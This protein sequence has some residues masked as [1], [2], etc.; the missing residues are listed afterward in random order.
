[1]KF[2]VIGYGFVGKAVVTTLEKNYKVNIIDPALGFEDT[3]EKYDVE[4]IILCLPA[5]TKMGGVVDHSI[6]S[7]YLEKIP[8]NIPVLIKSTITPK[9]AEENVKNN[10]AFSP[11]FL[12]ARNSIKDFEESKFIVFSGGMVSYWYDIF[13][14]LLPKLESVRFIKPTEAAVM[15]YSVNSFLATKLSFFNE[16]YDL[17]DNLDINYNEV[18]NALKLDDRMGNSH[19]DVPGFDGQRG[20]GGDCLPKDTKAFTTF[21][22]DNMSELTVIEAARKSN[23]KVRKL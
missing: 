22:R 1:M 4:G 13:K 12:T 3:P 7:N 18:I 21:A 8:D 16:I 15:K 17:C 11:E 9:F 19:F 14:D 6:I 20:W 10:V 2:T 23:Q 5:P